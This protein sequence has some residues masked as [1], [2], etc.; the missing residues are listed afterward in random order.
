MKNLFIGLM[1]AVLLLS[2]CADTATPI[3]PI[4]ELEYF[5]EQ[6][7]I[8]EPPEEAIP[9]P[10]AEPPTHHP[11]V[12]PEVV[13]HSYADEMMQ[14][15]T[16]F[17]V[18]ALFP[19]FEDLDSFDF[20]S[21][22]TLSTNLYMLALRR[23][24]AVSYQEAEVLI[25]RYYSGHPWNL[26]S[27]VRRDSLTMVGREFFG[28]DFYFPRGVFG[29]EVEPLD[30]Y[31]EFYA[32]PGRSVGWGFHRY[33][34][35]DISDEDDGRIVATFLPYTL[36]INPDTYPSPHSWVTWIEFL[37]PDHVAGRNTY[38]VIFEDYPG[39]ILESGASLGEI[40]GEVSLPV[41]QEGAP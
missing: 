38:N 24:Q 4:D 18:Q 12:M 8:E 32:K 33:L 14:L 29:V 1:L 2:A 6:P 39:V 7:E 30:P 19:R 21:D 25:E 37:N 22:W 41:P 28:E 40:L 23:S 35:L 31:S 34:L 11:F 9:S 15:L 17:S 20:A 26:G 3:R 36:Y 13:E 5:L 27:V 16:T 10:A